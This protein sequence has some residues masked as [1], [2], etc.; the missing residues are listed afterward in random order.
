M[1]PNPTKTSFVEARKAEKKPKNEQGSERLQPRDKLVSMSMTYNNRGFGDRKYSAMMQENALLPR[2]KGLNGFGAYEDPVARDTLEDSGAKEFWYYGKQREPG[3]VR[4]ESCCSSCGGALS[5]TNSFASTRRF[6]S[7]SIEIPN[8]SFIRKSLI[9]RNP[10]VTSGESLKYG[11]SS[12]TQR[13][14]G[15]ARKLEKSRSDQRMISK[16]QYDRM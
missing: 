2:G 7:V 14:K 6:S 8:E 16:S 4:R 10:S 3:L 1:P 5:Y 9:N 12:L 11:G 13:K 15:E